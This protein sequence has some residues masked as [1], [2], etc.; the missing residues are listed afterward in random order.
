MSETDLD[1]TDEVIF[2][3]GLSNDPMAEFSSALN[4]VQ[5]GAAPANLAFQ[6]KRAGVKRFVFASS[7]SVYGYTQDELN[8]EPAPATTTYPYGICKL[9]A[10]H[11]VRHLQDDTFSVTILR[12]GTVSGDSPRMRL[13]LI[14]NTM[15][16][17]ALQEA[18]SR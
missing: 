15:F 7:C 14:V 11:G 9:Q 8:D 6:A 1:G 17:T 10:E 4:F 3:A 13:D 5:N 2:L 16:K 12:Q 18:G